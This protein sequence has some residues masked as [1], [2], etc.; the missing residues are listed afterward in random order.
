MAA[1]P[2]SLQEFPFLFQ[3]DPVWTVAF[4]FADSLDISGPF[5]IILDYGPG[6]RVGVQALQWRCHGR[7]GS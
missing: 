3:F 2:V 1:A 7:L 4:D 6:R 5:W